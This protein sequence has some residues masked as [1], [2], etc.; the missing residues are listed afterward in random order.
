MHGRSMP[1][2]PAASYG[3]YPY[4]MLDRLGIFITIALTGQRGSRPFVVHVFIPRR[5]SR[6]WHD[7]V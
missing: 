1:L 6:F 5:S 3:E 2:A 4:R 7:S